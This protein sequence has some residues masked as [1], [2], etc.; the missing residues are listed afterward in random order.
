MKK[1]IAL[2]L[3]ALPCFAKSIGEDSNH[4][5]FSLYKKLEE[6]G[7]NLVFSPYGVFSN[8]ALLYFGAD[9]NTGKEIRRTLHMPYN[10]E[11]FLKAFRKQTDG[12]NQSIENGYQLNIANGLFI[13]ESLTLA[14]PFKQ[15]AKEDFKAKLTSINYSAPETATE[16]INNWIAKKTQDKIPKLL[17]KD[18]ITRAT[19]LVIANAIYFEGQWTYPFQKRETIA[20]PFYIEEG[21]T[22]AAEMMQQTAYFPYFEDD[23]VQC[24][25]LPF[26][27]A[28]TEQPFLVCAL[29]LPK[30]DLKELNK[31]INEKD[32]INWLENK[33]S[34]LI[35]AKI[36]KF[37]FR[38]RFELN[39]ALQSLGI[40]DAFS[41]NADFS[42]IDG[43]KSLS[44]TKFLQETYFAFDE[45]GVT[46]AS[47]TA[48]V[49]SKTSAPPKVETT[50]PF[51]ADHPFLF[52]VMDYHLKTVLFMGH[53]TNPAS[54]ECNEN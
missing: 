18:D 21:K 28:G 7:E 22:I 45:N 15:I 25:F 16:T 9:K 8:L 23:D 43:S 53:V 20:A 12:L 51:T 29:I 36:P 34:A 52:L 46:A 48:G 17:L 26:E 30:E 10:T 50:T 6:K 40:K 47:A 54:G 38:Q 14:A 5:G 27:R 39:D 31:S 19:R 3:I 13:D 11:K 41:S 35:D 42:G 2:L 49:M 1:I 44:L 32:L 37:C 4:F 24:L 33:Q